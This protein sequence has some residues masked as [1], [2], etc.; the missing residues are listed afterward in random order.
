ML[1]HTNKKLLYISVIHVM[2]SL[3]FN[4]FGAIAAVTS[5]S[6]PEE[7]RVRHFLLG[8]RTDR[9]NKGLRQRG[10]C[11]TG[12]ARRL[13]LSGPNVS[14]TSGRGGLRSG[15]KE[16][17]SAK[18][19]RVKEGNGAERLARWWTVKDRSRSVCAKRW[20]RRVYAVGTEETLGREWPPVPKHLRIFVFRIWG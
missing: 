12:P 20:K 16:G 10:G 14:V 13:A 1:S 3:Y 15:G 9:R 2:T 8:A 17:E 4:K 7:E 19:S 6:K 11:A 18:D 5:L